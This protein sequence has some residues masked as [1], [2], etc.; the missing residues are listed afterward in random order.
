MNRLTADPLVYAIWLVQQQWHIAG[1]L[2][3]LGGAGHA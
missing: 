1:C 3:M 2:Q